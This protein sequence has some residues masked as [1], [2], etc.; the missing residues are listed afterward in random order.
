MAESVDLECKEAQGRDGRG[1]LPGDVWKSYCA[2]ANTDGGTIL[3]GVQEKP[4]IGL[5]II[6]NRDSAPRGFQKITTSQFNIIMRETRTD[7]SIVVD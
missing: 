3:L 7:E 1:E 6:K 4:A 5:G 2:M